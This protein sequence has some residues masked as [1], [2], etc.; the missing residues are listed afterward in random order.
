MTITTITTIK[1][2]ILIKALFY[3]DFISGREVGIETGLLRMNH[4]PN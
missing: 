4:A 2:K 1:I 3:I